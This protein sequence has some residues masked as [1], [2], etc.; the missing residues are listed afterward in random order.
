MDIETAKN[1]LKLFEIGL[2]NERLSMSSTDALL[3]A[4]RNVAKQKAELGK[5]EAELKAVL[6][7]FTHVLV[8]DNLYFVRF[9]DSGTV[10]NSAAIKDYRVAAG[11]GLRLHVPAQTVQTPMAER[12]KAALDK[13]VSFDELPE[14]RLKDVLGFM[15]DKAGVDVPFR[16]LGKSQDESVSL[17]KA[18]LP[19]G[20]WLQALEDSVPNLRFVVR[21]YGILATTKDRIP[22]GAMTVQ[23]FW[24]QGD[25]AKTPAP[26]PD[27]EPE[28][29]KKP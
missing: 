1:A 15:T 10:E 16:V 17:M 25:K 3:T 28:A 21:E 19:V 7:S 26:K 23:E 27:K 5:L 8:N 12:I 4:E 11:L 14:A 22:D 2:K 24:K 13:T 6:G 20:A 29:A 9:V 18:E